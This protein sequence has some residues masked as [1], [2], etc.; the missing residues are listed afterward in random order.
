MSARLHLW[1][2]DLYA[3]VQI[4]IYIYIYISLYIYIYINK[5]VQL[6][7][8]IVSRAWGCL[9]SPV[10]CSSW[11]TPGIS[12][13]ETRLE[14][15]KLKNQTKEIILWLHNISIEISKRFHL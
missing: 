2:F 3:N 12:L 10:H 11:N 6:F 14:L 4:Y 7:Y 5:L 8:S 9:L 13:H 15:P 1:N